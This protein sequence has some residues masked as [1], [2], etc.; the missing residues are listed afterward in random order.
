M[1]LRKDVKHPFPAESDEV[2]VTK[3]KEEGAGPEPRKTAKARSPRAKPATPPAAKAMTIDFD[4]IANRV[5]R[6]PIGADNYGGISAKPG[7]LIYGVGP[8]FYYGR[9]GDRPAQLKI[10]S[11][12]DRKETTLVDD[13]GGYAMSRDGSKVLVRRAQASVFTMRRRKATRAANPFD[14]RPDG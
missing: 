1:A 5:A 3:P 2:A 4:G 10:F 6:V 8:A 13:G 12:K 14:G 11:L 9:Q 7:F